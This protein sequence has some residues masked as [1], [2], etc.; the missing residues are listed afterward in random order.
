MDGPAKG[1]RPHIIP[2]LLLESFIS[3]W[4]HTRRFQVLCTDTVSS[5]SDVDL[6]R[7]FLHST[8]RSLQETPCRFKL[9][10]VLVHRRP[11]II[12]WV[13]LRFLARLARPR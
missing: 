3:A 10:G 9:R 11:E 12:P 7:H 13:F 1:T 8:L 2:F 4:A 5:L 6:C